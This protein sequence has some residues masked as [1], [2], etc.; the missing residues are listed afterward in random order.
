MGV[1][2]RECIPE[3]H[4]VHLQWPIDVGNGLGDSKDLV[5]VGVRLVRSKIR[6]LGDVM[7][8]SV[9]RDHISTTE[10][11]ALQIRVGVR[12]SHD[13]NAE[14]IVIGTAVSARGAPDPLLH[15]CEVFWPVA[16]AKGL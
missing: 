11:F 7:I 1:Q 6:Q 8:S 5:P 16:H 14:P 15:A 3:D 13:P 4:Q 9:D 12:S 2:V 10:P